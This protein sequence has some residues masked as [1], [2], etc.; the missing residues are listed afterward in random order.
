METNKKIHFIKA[1]CHQST[2]DQGFQFAPDEVKEKYDYE[3][4]KSLFNNSVV[5]I[6]NNKFELCK[7]YD[8]LYQYI[9]KYS[10]DNPD[11]IIVTIG[12]DHSISTGTVAG[13]NEKYLNVKG[14]IV[15][16][17]LMVLWLDCHP[18]LNDFN[19]SMTKDLNEM[20]V[21]T[22]IGLVDNKFT[23]QKLIMK[24]EQF[25]YYGLIDDES[26]D[27]VKELHIPY[28]SVNKIKNVDSKLIINKIKELVGSRP[29][30]ISLDMKV[31]NSSIVKSVVPP[32]DKG[33]SYENV[34]NVITALKDNIV[35]MDIVEFNPLKGNKIDVKNTR[36][37]I[38]E[39]L[40]KT[41][42][43]KE[44]SINIF[45]EHSEF[46]IY[47]PLE[48]LDFETDIG[49]YILRGVS[50]K[51]REELMGLVKDDVIV[52]LDI[53]DE[54]YLVTKTTIDEQ[55]KKNYYMASSINDAILFPDEKKDMGFELIN[56]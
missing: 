3:I 48:Q 18:D 24:P 56:C 43:I 26:V 30:H 2:R 11:S 33:L 12:G 45:N 15:E 39:I 23:K 37:L 42:D 1:A 54:T 52:S 10:K 55:N 7:G 28:F 17:D 53:E 20:P 35:S 49:W 51:D 38:R 19:T 36:E 8:H 41:F 31:F 25:I 46:L 16:S 6:E 21:A 27:K 50:L 44:K 22:L 4:E 40:V 29:I 34:L 32:N 47:R 13:I 9:L 5:D 14:D